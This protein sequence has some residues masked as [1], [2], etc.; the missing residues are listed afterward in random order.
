MPYACVYGGCSILW[1]CI[2]YVYIFHVVLE[3]AWMKVLTSVQNKGQ[4]HV[5]RLKNCQEDRQLFEN[6]LV[7]LLLSWSLCR[8]LSGLAVIEVWTLV[9]RPCTNRLKDPWPGPLLSIDSSL[10]HRLRI[11]KIS[12]SF[13]QFYHQVTESVF[14]MLHILAWLLG[15]NCT[16]WNFGTLDCA[17]SLHCNSVGIQLT[18]IRPKIT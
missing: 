3:I 10:I 7:T 16:L 6:F 14:P 5:P 4:F 8:K 9:L 2:F 12:F 17:L 11:N 15:Q 13:V 18:F 1:L